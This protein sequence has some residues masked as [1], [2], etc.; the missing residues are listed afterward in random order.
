MKKFIKKVTDFIV[1]IF[2]FLV[3]AVIVVFCLFLSKVLFEA[4]V[5]SNMPDWLKYVLLK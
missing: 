4:I 3:G 1:M 5:N 2:P